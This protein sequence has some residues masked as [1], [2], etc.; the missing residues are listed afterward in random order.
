ME[1]AYVPRNFFFVA[2]WKLRTCPKESLGVGGAAGMDTVAVALCSGD[3]RLEGL[4]LAR[5]VGRGLHTPSC[6][7]NAAGW[8]R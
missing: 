2:C 4:Y 7:P 1:Q 6:C 8:W 5:V 3:K